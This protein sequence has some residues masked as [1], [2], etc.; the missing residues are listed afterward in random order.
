MSSELFQSAMKPNVAVQGLAVGLTAFLTAGCGRD[1]QA[2]THQSVEAAGA[3][4]RGACSHAACGNDFFVDVGS[5]GGCAVGATCTLSLTLVA[6]GDYHIN[7]EY[8]Y[9][10]TADDSPGVQF[11]GTDGGRTN[12]FSKLAKNWARR[13]ERTG[14]MTVTFKPVEKGSKAIDGVFK[15]SVCSVQ[16]CQ[17]EQEQVKAT[18][19]VR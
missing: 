11:L 17:L 3:P 5:V 14:T 4:L 19:V 2:A 12:V 9:K 7:D 18:V 13:D 16:N 8:P 6:T 10:F 1:S 15:L